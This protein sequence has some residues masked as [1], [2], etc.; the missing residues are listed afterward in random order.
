MAARAIWKGPLQVGELSC[1]VPLHTAASSSERISFHFVNRKTGNR[2]HCEYVDEET[3][4]PVEREDQARGYEATRG[5]YIVLEPEEV[6][7]AVPHADKRLAVESFIPCD[8]VDTVYLDKPYYVT[9]ADDT[10]EDA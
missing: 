1:A 6:A 4:R 5:D 8:E 7:A 3:G 9:P 2:V 10:A